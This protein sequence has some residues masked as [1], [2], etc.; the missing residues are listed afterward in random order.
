MVVYMSFDDK[1]D[2][3][4]I[5]RM[6]QDREDQMYH[7]PYSRELANFGHIKYGDASEID[8]LIEQFLHNTTSRLSND[9]L[10]CKKYLF[11]AA[12]TLAVRFAI[13]GGLNQELAYTLS[14]QYIQKVDRCRTI[15][16]VG[17]IYHDMYVEFAS[18]VR[19]VKAKR[20]YSRKVNEAV[21]YIYKHLHLRISLAEM[22]KTIGISQSYFSILFKREVGISCSEYI[23]KEKANYARDLLEYSDLSYVDISNYLAFSSHS[24]FISVFKKEYG[25]T[26]REY[27]NAHYNSH[28]TSLYGNSF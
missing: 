26:P 13:E 4:L 23:R 20:V 6:F 27:R 2:E 15:E 1:K 25:T 7:R 14:D 28:Y 21:D 16:E 11:V 8:E 10:R 19:E 24:H 12:I 18:R 3:I 5:E 9:P 17:E 22:C